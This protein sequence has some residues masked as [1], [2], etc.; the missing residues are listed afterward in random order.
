[1]PMAVIVLLALFS[2]QVAAPAH[3]QGVRAIMLVWFATIAVLGVGGI[4]HRRAFLPQSIRPTRWDSC[5]RTR[6]SDS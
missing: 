4:L 5:W 3:R 6:V 1:M 2:V